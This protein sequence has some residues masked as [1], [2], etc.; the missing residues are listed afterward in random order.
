MPSFEHVVTEA[1]ASWLANYT[2][3]DERGRLRQL[4]GLYHLVL[5][6]REAIVSALANGKKNLDSLGSREPGVPPC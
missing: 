2:V 5:N 3:G 6:N 1:R 4:H